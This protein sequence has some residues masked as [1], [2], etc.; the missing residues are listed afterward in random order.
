[1]KWIH[2]LLNFSSPVYRGVW[3]TFTFDVQRPRKRL[4]EW[5]RLVHWWWRKIRMSYRHCVWVLLHSLIDWWT[6]IRVLLC[7]PSSMQY[8][9]LFFVYFSVVI[10]MGE[11][12]MEVN[13]YLTIVSKSNRWPSLSSNKQTASVQIC[14]VGWSMSARAQSVSQSSSVWSLGCRQHVLTFLL[15]SSNET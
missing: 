9:C 13:L 4:G 8:V 15:I 14:R 2:Y 5:S 12:P 6:N 10:L 11:T 7:G 3:S 1:M